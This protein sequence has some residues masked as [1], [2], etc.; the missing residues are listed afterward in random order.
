MKDI[1]TTNTLLLIIVLPIIFYVL[2]ILS[3]IFIPLI[4][5]MFIA[6]LFLPLM[7]W[8]KKKKVPKS[9]SVFIVILIIGGAL[10]IGGKLIQLS[11]KEIVSS[12]DG[13]FEKA[14]IK[15]EILLK[16]IEEFFGIEYIEGGN[17]LNHL[18]QKDNL[19]QNFGSTVDFIS[20]TLSL[21]LMTAFFV[22]LWLGESINFQKLLNDTILKQKHASIKAF[23]KIENDLIKFMKVKFIISLGTG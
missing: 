19:I 2:K 7:R 12:K 6:L 14:L 15:I 3:F 16:S 17:V 13:F 1:K 22:V 20:D 9:I 11:S 8:F 18:L 10:K 4:F 5:S 21:T 23:M